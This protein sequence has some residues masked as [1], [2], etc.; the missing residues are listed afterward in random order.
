LL[1][2][3]FVVI[4]KPQITKPKHESQATSHWSRFKFRN[5][6]FA[7]RISTPRTTIHKFI[8]TPQSAFLITRRLALFH[9]S[10]ISLDHD[11]LF[12]I[13]IL[14]ACLKLRS[15][16]EYNEECSVSFAEIT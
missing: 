16:V 5:P 10:G 15:G 7:F 4:F 9:V 13:Y 2:Q 3:P 14:K 1:G 6:H 11:V 12:A 8:A